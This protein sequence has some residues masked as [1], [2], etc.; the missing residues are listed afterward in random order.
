VSRFLVLAAL[1]ALVVSGGA[2]STSSDQMGRFLIAYVAGGEQRLAQSRDGIRWT[3]VADLAAQPGA[4]PSAVR[5]GRTLY[6]FDGLRIVPEGLTG[7]VRRFRVGSSSLT[8]LPP[9]QFTVQLAT[10]LDL[11]RA[12][13]VSGSVAL[14]DAGR[15]TALFALRFEAET[16]ACPVS[17]QACV[18][19]RTAT[20][21]AGTD[22]A[23]F[24]G[25]SGNRAVLSF[26]SGD[27]VREP[28]G[29]AT[30]KGYL[31]AL[32]GP[33]QCLRLLKAS[34]L[35]GSYR[36][37]PKLAGSCLADQVSLGTP[38]G[39]YRPFLKA[40]WLYGVSEGRVVR[41]STRT[42]TRELPGRRFRPV[43]LPGSPS[44]TSARFA[45]N[46]P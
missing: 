1:C 30:A 22:G 12:D 8:E 7:E 10:P 32:S 15:L 6:V 31:V 23:L 41:A 45:L 43:R 42:L 25:D 36:A 3:A 34:D 26:A 14:D 24:T 29:F 11:Q 18:K 19:V 28:A 37:M 5:R 17:G 44:V 27:D 33:G 9:S 21:A 13:A 2:T 16:N 40:H 38:T 4:A 20:E 35:H 39:A 46:A